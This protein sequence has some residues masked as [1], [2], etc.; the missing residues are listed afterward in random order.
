M[1]WSR[2]PLP[3]VGHLVLYYGYLHKPIC[4]F[5]FTTSVYSIESRGMLCMPLPC[6]HG[7]HLGRKFQLQIPSASQTAR[8]LQRPPYV[9]RPIA[10]MHHASRPKSPLPGSRS[11]SLSFKCLVAQVGMECLFGLGNLR[12]FLPTFSRPHLHELYLNPLS[13]QQP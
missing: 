10:E 5:G 2:F 8:S 9:E 6:T 3:P 13:L 12:E 7:C 11:C 1:S 4:S